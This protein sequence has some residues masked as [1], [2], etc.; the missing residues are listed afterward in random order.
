MNQIELDTHSFVIKIWLEEIIELSG[1][2]LWRGHITHVASGEKKPLK[3][4]REIVPFIGDY[5]Q[6]E[7]AEAYGLLEDCHD[8]PVS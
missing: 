4:M 3:S 6:A 8:K 7:A 2:A 1:R 5:L